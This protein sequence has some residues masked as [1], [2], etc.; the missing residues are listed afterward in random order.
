MGRVYL[1]QDEMA[2]FGYTEEQ[3]EAG[4]RNDAFIELLRFPG[5]SGRGH[6][7]AAASGC[8]PT[9]HV[10][11]GPA[12]PFLGAIYSKLLDRIEASG[13]DVLGEQR[14]ALST[15]EKA[16]I[17]ARAWLASTL[18]SATATVIPRGR[19]PQRGGWGIIVCPRGPE[20]A[21][22]T[23]GRNGPITNGSSFPPR[24]KSWA[25]TSLLAK[26]RAR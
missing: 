3:L 9:F 17:T 16:R 8:C 12:R 6:T 24:N 4:I 25:G 14:V 19:I 23:W 1:P 20:C 21:G 26:N 5:G 15:R 18:A 13:Y 11:A 10:A 22:L 2:R 7:T